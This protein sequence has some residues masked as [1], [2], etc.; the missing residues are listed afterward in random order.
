MRAMNEEE[1]KK[2]EEVQAESTAESI[3]LREVF[4]RYSPVHKVQVVE[5]TWKNTVTFYT[6]WFDP[7]LGSKR[8]ADITVDDIQ[9]VINKVLAERTPRTAEYMKAVI[10]QIFNFAIDRNLYFKNNP[11]LKITLPSFDNKRTFF[12]SNEQAEELI[13]KLY[14]HREIVGDMVNLAFHTGCRAS[15]IF[16]LEWKNVDF[17]NQFLILLDTKHA[18]KT[19]YIPMDDVALE[20]LNKRYKID[21]KG[22]I[23]KNKNGEAFKDMPDCYNQVLEEMGLR[24]EGMTRKELP[25]FHSVRHTFASNLVINNVNLREVQTLMGHATSQMT[26]RYSHL[27]PDHL[28]KAI[29]KLNYKN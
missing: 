23:F 10:R 4:E 13:R 21:N 20:I 15:E 2:K 11:A 16:K 28:K 27:A 7:K 9:E 29:S 22:I 5:K 17:N 19:R 14:E 1:A 25:V 26:E 3:T 18:K 6:H 8:I 12:F 24:K